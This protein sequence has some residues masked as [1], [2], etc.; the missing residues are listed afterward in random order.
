LLGISE[1]EEVIAILPGSRGSEIK[2]LGETFIKT[3]QYCLNKKPNLRF[4]I[5]CV[6]STRQQEVQNIIHNIAPD[7]PAMLLDGQA[8]QAMAAADTILLASGTATLEALLLKKPMVVAYR[9]ATITFMIAKWM[10]KTPFISLPNLLAGREVVPEI[11]QDDATPE[12][13]GEALLAQLTDKNKMHDIENCFNDI[14]LSLKHD[15]DHQAATAVLDLLH[16][17]GQLSYK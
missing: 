13:L 11:L 16:Q 3:A 7:L 10:V 1:Q 6:N 4:L 14:H 12:K 9:V 5:P 15:A 8:Q 2:Y 17:H